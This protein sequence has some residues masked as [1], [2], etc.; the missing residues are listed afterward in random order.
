[1]NRLTSKLQTRTDD[2]VTKLSRRRRTTTSSVIL[3]TVACH[4][5]KTKSLTYFLTR[6][7]CLA[8]RRKSLN[9]NSKKRTSNRLPNRLVMITMVSLP[10]LIVIYNS[11]NQILTSGHIWVGF[12]M[13]LRQSRMER[14]WSVI[15]KTGQDQRTEIVGPF[16][17][18]F[19]QCKGYPN[20]LKTTTFAEVG[21]C[22]FLRNVSPHH[23]FG[24]SGGLK[25]E[26]N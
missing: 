18:I 10:V 12:V 26:F 8:A 17:F 23:N 3:V 5:H 19:S 15:E 9:D 6:G 7:L 11:S 1:M 13:K 20:R 16:T 22:V 24:L 4:P 14:L 25:F 21:V 2:I